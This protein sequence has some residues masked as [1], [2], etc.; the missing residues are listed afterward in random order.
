M[1]YIAGFSTFESLKLQND[2][3]FNFN[4]E[5]K[6]PENAADR[7]MTQRSSLALFSDR[8]PFTEQFTPTLGSSDATVFVE[9]TYIIPIS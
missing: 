4:C 3:C 6:L 8:E 2:G 5:D 9:G 7:Q 1:I